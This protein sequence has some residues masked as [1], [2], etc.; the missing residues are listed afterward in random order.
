MAGATSML[1]SD[2]AKSTQR[3]CEALLSCRSCLTWKV[4]GTIGAVLEPH[5]S[6]PQAQA[7]PPLCRNGCFSAETSNHFFLSSSRLPT[8][9][10]RKFALGRRCAT[11][12]GRA[13]QLDV[14]C[15]MTSEA[16]PAKARADD[17]GCG[18]RTRESHLLVCGQ[19]FPCSAAP[20]ISSREL[21]H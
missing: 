18:T 12:A 9:R 21:D 7:D 1:N 15:S 5:Q 20:C 2:R 8:L 17:R 6:G 11:W 3:H 4:R 10:G 13:R 19:I 14:P 16:R